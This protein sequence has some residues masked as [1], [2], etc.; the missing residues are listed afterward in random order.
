MF[1]IIILFISLINV[2]PTLIAIGNVIITFVCE[3]QLWTDLN[4]NCKL[5]FDKIVTNARFNVILFV[6]MLLFVWV[7]SR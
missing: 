5:T 6:V 3:I 7:E 4:S 2:T 1:V